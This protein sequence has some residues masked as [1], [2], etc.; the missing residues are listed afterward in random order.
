[1]VRM[2]DEY[3]KGTLPQ[4]VERAR[5]LKAKIP[6]HLPRDYG[7]LIAACENELDKIISVLRSLQNWSGTRGLND[8]RLRQFKRAV[9][10]LDFIEA[11]G[12]AA[13]S[14]AQE[15]DHHANRLI[16]L[17]CQE[18]KHPVAS[19]TVTTLS[20]DYFY[21][22]TELNLMFIPPAEGSF[23]L[24]L[25]DVYHEL[26]HPLLTRK[27]HPVL[28]RFRSRYLRCVAA[29]HDHFA[30]ERDKYSR[31]RGPQGFACQVDQYEH[32]WSK[33]WLTELFCDLYAVATLG[34]AYAWSHL[35]LYLKRG[36]DAY[37]VPDGMRLAR[38]PAD[39]AR[40][41]VVLASLRRAGFLDE[42]K[43]ISARWQDALQRTTSG[44]P[45]P[46][47]AH[48]YPD[49]LLNKVVEEAMLGVAE[50]ECRLAIQGTDDRVHVM[51][52]QAWKAFW[53][54][55][56]GYHK[57]ESVAVNELSVL[58]GGRL[59]LPSEVSALG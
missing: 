20:T 48:C 1:M 50:M 29:V 5:L 25:P 32:L 19:P 39:D 3:F 31:R 59:A 56:D 45:S 57:W 34:P 46:D 44:R 36:G 53:A 18:I 51:L 47:Y 37:W 22:D 55:P 49:A 9:A 58:C 11:R 4:L 23:L 10:D 13:L 7:A 8:V 30:K 54:D 15:D 40:M 35:H 42:E 2:L 43:Q 17:I 24:H 41:Q 16:Y 6:R 12:I 21:I 52:N 38:H 27:D 33:Y 14:R 26:G 28:D